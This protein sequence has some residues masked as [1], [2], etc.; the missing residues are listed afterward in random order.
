MAYSYTSFRVPQ[1][2]TS[3]DY[4]IVDGAGKS[5]RDRCKF[6][7]M[8]H[9]R[10][11]GIHPLICIKPSIII[12][13]LFITDKEISDERFCDIDINTGCCRISGGTPP[14]VLRSRIKCGVILMP[15]ARYLKIRLISGQKLVTHLGCY[16]IFRTT[17]IT[18]DRKIAIC[19]RRIREL[20]VDKAGLEFK[21]N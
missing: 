7:H 17:L 21:V 2:R 3:N 20:I 6:C 11:A 1:T 18:V 10:S 14:Q 9:E 13:L 8:P 16:R 5:Q 4:R 12:K 15:S 19:G